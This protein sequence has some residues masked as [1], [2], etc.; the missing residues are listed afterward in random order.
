MKLK[1]AFVRLLEDLLELEGSFAIPFEPLGPKLRR[2]AANHMSDVKNIR[3]EL[4]DAAAIKI[5][6]DMISYDELHFLMT[7]MDDSPDSGQDI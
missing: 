3:E 5:D 7:P 1:R 4:D 2:I 6:S